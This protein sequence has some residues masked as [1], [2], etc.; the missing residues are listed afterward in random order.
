MLLAEMFRRVIMCVPS[1]NAT[2]KAPNCGKLRPA[3]RV[4]VTS[5][6]SIDREGVTVIVVGR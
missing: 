1:G 2:D 4:P 3:S 6:I 5:V